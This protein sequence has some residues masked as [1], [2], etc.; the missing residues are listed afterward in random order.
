MVNDDVFYCYCYYYYCYYCCLNL[1]R[2]DRY[3]LLEHQQETSFQ[4]GRYSRSTQQNLLWKKSSDST[5]ED[6]GMSSPCSQRCIFYNQ[7]NRWVRGEHRDVRDSLWQCRD[8]ALEHAYGF[9][10]PSDE[11]ALMMQVSA[12]SASENEDEH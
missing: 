10:S 7:C 11:E 1:H 4:A 12:N 2:L 6:E 3:S 8:C 5:A 9:G